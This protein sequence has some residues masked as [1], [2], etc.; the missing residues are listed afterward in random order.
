[1]SADRN[2]KVEFWTADG[3][4]VALFTGARIEIF[5]MTGKN[6]K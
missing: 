6:A 1:V 2:Y 3:Q 4:H 5:E